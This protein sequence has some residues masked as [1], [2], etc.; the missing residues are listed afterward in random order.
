MLINIFLLILSSIAALL[1]I[2]RYQKH[3][4]KKR[5]RL[6][7]ETWAIGIYKGPSPINLFPPEGITNP[8]ISAKDV[9]DIK[10]RFVADPFMIQNINGYYLFFEVLNEK[11]NTGE[12]AYAFSKDMMKWQYRN[13]VLRER[14][15]LSYPS[16]FLWEERYFMIPESYNSGGI[17]LYQA[18][19]FPDTWQYIRTIIKRSGRYSALVDPT[20]ILYQKHWYLFSYAPKSKNLHLFTSNTLT[21]QWQ[22]H[23][24]S[25]I[26]HNSPH[27]ARPGGKVIMHNGDI[28]RYAQDETPNYGTKV[29]AIQITE[30]SEKNYQEKAPEKHPVVEPGNE[31]WNKDGMHTVD[32]HQIA[33]G[34]WIALVDGFTIKTVS[35]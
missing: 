17:R 7:R 6:S 34:E 15:H 32:A 10:A 28:Y 26:V 9:T 14:F 27:F 22:E 13:I 16:V 11:R 23:P 29:W 4:K 2:A 35:E 30:L 19:N 12:I 8:I 31:W 21:G 1:F 3:R 18:K 5:A 20:V 33:S 25:P 24:K